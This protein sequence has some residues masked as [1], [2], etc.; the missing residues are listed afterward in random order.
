MHH[1]GGGGVEVHSSRSLK[2]IM[3]H[4]FKS[5]RVRA[6]E[7]RL[8]AMDTRHMTDGW[9]DGRMERRR[10]GLV[11]PFPAWILSSHHT[12][13]HSAVFGSVSQLH[14]YLPASSIKHL[15]SNFS[16]VLNLQCLLSNFPPQKQK[17]LVS[18]L[19]LTESPFF[20]CRRG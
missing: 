6:A 16:K 3:C 4:S 15:F 20:L 7:A 10:K 5:L 1:G 14:Y 17:E 2:C 12:D 18:L 11:G 8:S 9:M 13:R 19:P